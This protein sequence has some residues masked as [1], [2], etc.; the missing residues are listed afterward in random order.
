MAEDVRWEQRFSNYRR[1]L[2]QLESF[3]QSPSLNERE[4][5]GL[6]KAFKYTFE[7]GWN[8]LRSRLE[9]RLAEAKP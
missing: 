8:T 6:I 9:Q 2:A 5:Q 4:Q 7:L 3:L 1:A